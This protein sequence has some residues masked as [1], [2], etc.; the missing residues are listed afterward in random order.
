M[1]MTTGKIFGVLVNSG[2]CIALDF[3]MFYNTYSEAAHRCD[4][5]FAIEI[6][7]VFVFRFV[8]HISYRNLFSVIYRFHEQPIDIVFGCM[9]H[10]LDGI[11]KI[12]IN[13][14]ELRG[15]DAFKIEIFRLKCIK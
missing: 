7:E 15:R 3:G 10:A 2:H 1:N 13:K 8:I 11:F 14:V 4:M 5:T 6:F 12:S 9:K